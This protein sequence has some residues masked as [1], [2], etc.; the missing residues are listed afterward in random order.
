MIKIPIEINVE[1]GKKTHYNL[2]HFLIAVNKLQGKR[3]G[4]T[5]PFKG[6]TF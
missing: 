4:A 2:P 1:K 3:R 6:D 5:S